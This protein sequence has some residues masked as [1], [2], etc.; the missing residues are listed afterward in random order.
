MTVTEFIHVF[1]TT[2]LASHADAPDKNTQLCHLQHLML[3]ATDYGWEA[4]K[5]AHVVILQEME[6]GRITW[7][8][9]DSIQDL[10]YF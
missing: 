9:E 2:F 8:N 10:H 4:A 6:A 1:V 5:H 3:D 7:A